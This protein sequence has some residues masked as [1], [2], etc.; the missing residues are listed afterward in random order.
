VPCEWG[1]DGCVDEGTD[2]GIDGDWEVKRGR[3]SE[4]GKRKTA[5]YEKMNRREGMGNGSSERMS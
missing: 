1:I 3:R 2:R 4:I 5:G